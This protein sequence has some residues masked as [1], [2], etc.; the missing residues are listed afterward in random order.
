APIADEGAAK[1][2]YVSTR[3]F[4]T[5]RVV[6]LQRGYLADASAARAAL[7]RLRRGVGQPYGALVDLLEYEVNPAT[8]RPR[9]DAP[10][11]DEIAIH[12][13]LTLYALHQQSQDR[14]MH[15]PRT[16]FGTALGVLR[17]R[18]GEENAGVIRRFQAVGT[19]SD[20]PELA[21]HA[22]AL[23][24]LLRAAERGFDYGRFA[25]DLVALQ[26]PGRAGGVRLRWGRDF[27]RV[28]TPS[29]SPETEEQQS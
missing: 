28:V 6:E 19:A 14:P 10:S 25:A 26:D 15:V 20:F 8:P 2:R 16:S 21:Q 4:V 22:R 3:D 12:T 23:I 24:T 9:G 29:D 5:R 1:P 27:F 11:A 7:A 18:D 17:Y 13:A